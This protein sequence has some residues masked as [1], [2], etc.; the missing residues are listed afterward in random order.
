MGRS[1]DTVQYPFIEIICSNGV[2]LTRSEANYDVNLKSSPYRPDYFVSL[3]HKRT[4]DGANTFT[5]N[6][7]FVPN[8]AS[9]KGVNWFEQQLL[10]STGHIKFRYG[11]TT[12]D[13]SEWSD[14]Y[15]GF[16]ESYSCTFSNG[17]LKYTVSGISSSVIAN[18][19][20]IEDVD[21]YSIYCDTSDG[22]TKDTAETV[23]NKIER[24]VNKDSSL[25]DYYIFDR[26]NSSSNFEVSGDLQPSKLAPMTYLHKVAKDCIVDKEDK[27]TYFYKIIVDDVDRNGKGR[28]RLQR[29][30]TNSLSAVYTFDWGSKDC[31]VISWNPSYDGSVA[32]IFSRNR[33]KIETVK[34][35]TEDTEGNLSGGEITSPEDKD[36]ND[37]NTNIFSFDN[38]VSK[39]VTNLSTFLEAS[40]YLYK[41]TI[42]V[43]GLAGK[44]AENLSIVTSIIEVNPLINGQRHHSAGFYNVL[45]IT[46]KVSSSGFTTTLELQRKA[47]SSGNSSAI[48]SDK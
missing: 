10:E 1:Y 14:F 13:P 33:D 17:V 29:Y 37:D 25:K 30:N 18:L 26:D 39:N 42:T 6:F 12:A 22:H 43:L 38:S 45:G 36:S 9:G 27:K 40:N 28:I 11:M 24:L 47:D 21:A 8:E 7:D 15:F 48:H 16:I 44:K 20:D 46:D 19:D 5:F 41:A 2:C 4:I 34:R 23:L 32:L 31:D 3:E 35:Y